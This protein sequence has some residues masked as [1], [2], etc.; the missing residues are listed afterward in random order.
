MRAEVT[1]KTNEIGPGPDYKSTPVEPPEFETLAL[2]PESEQDI[3]AC[4]LLGKGILPLFYEPTGILIGG[5]VT[6]PAKVLILYA[7]RR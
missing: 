4:R 2:L 3:E 7:S 1:W 5:K 6:H